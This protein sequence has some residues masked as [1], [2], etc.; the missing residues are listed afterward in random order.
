ML[1]SVLY[2]RN[3]IHLSHLPNPPN[4]LHRFST[5]VA[6]RSKWFIPQNIWRKKKTSFYLLSDPKYGQFAVELAL[7]DILDWSR[8]NALTH[9]FFLLIIASQVTY[10]WYLFITYPPIKRIRRWWRRWDERAYLTLFAVFFLVRSSSYWMREFRYVPFVLFKARIISYSGPWD[11][12]CVSVPE[13]HREPSVAFR[14]KYSNSFYT[15]NGISPNNAMI[16]IEALYSDEWM[17]W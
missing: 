7:C 13:L 1:I 3:N 16:K 14:F 12:V 5:V 17:K 8:L 6:V 15:L 4:Q 11:G 2:M 10:S 9:L